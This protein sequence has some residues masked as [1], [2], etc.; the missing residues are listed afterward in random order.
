MADFRIKDLP[1]G[2]FDD[3]FFFA[4]TALPLTA[5]FI[6]PIDL[7]CSKLACTLGRDNQFYLDSHHLNVAGNKKFKAAFEAVL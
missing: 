5:T 2:P 3:N 7:F 1:T 6:N 4:N